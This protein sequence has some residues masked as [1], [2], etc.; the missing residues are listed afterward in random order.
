MTMEEKNLHRG[1]NASNTGDRFVVS[2]CIA[3]DTVLPWDIVVKDV[4]PDPQ[5]WG[6]S[7]SRSETGGR[8]PLRMK[9]SFYSAKDLRK[10]THPIQKDKYK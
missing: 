2:I 9:T 4:D 5:P 6:T 10:H 1:G 7:S 3:L 8:Q